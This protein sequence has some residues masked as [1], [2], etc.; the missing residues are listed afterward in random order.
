MKED[1]LVYLAM[2]LAIC[3]GSLDE[4]ARCSFN[5]SLGESKLRMSQFSPKKVMYN[6]YHNM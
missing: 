5:S 1:S 2:A 3:D 6:Q 4:L